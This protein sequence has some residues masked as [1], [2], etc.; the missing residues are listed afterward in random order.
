[1]PADT[2]LSSV[3]DKDGANVFG[4]VIV[5]LTGGRECWASITLCSDENEPPIG[6]VGDVGELTDPAF[7]FFCDTSYGAR[8]SDV[9]DANVLL[10]FRNIIG[11][12]K[13][14]KDFVYDQKIA[15]LLKADVS[16]T[17]RRCPTTATFGAPSNC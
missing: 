1:M 14:R 3:W 5:V 9:S 6:W 15:Y 12:C 10:G 2:L 4:R 16:L 17:L 13:E 7:R 11:L 8:N